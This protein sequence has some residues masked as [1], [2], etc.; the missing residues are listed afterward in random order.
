MNALVKP[1]GLL[2]LAA[3]F[4]LAWLIFSQLGSTS[5]SPQCYGATAAAAEADPPSL[6]PGYEPPADWDRVPER[7]APDAS[8]PLPPPAYV[9]ADDFP[10]E[11]GPPT[12][13]QPVIVDEWSEPTRP[14]R[15]P[16][17]PPRPSSSPARPGNF[18]GLTFPAYPSA[19]TNAPSQDTDEPPAIP[20][21]DFPEQGP[22]PIR[23]PKVPTQPDRE[24]STATIVAPTWSQPRSARVT[25][26]VHYINTTQIEL[27]YEVT[28]VGP[29]GVG[30]VDLWLTLDQGQTWRRFAEDMDL[31]S[32][33]NVDLPAEGIYGLTLIVRNRAGL[34]KEAPMRGDAPEMLVEVDLTA[35]LVLLK[36]PQPIKDRRDQ[37]TLSWE[38]SDRY[39]TESPVTLSWSDKADGPWNEIVANLANTSRYLWTMPARMPHRIYLKLEARDRAGNIGVAQSAEPVLIDL[40]EPESKLTGVAPRS[41]KPFEGLMRRE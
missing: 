23:T 33:I 31:R 3:G 1:V 34:G 25:P 32:P 5:Q 7:S 4:G 18:D 28:Q 30:A 20:Y 39:L 17:L 41:R 12:P 8:G 38:A 37:L 16:Y 29:A 11:P 21:P 35:P 24:G 13:D 36:A 2:G 22:R 19:P 40:L 6:P 27:S 9:P 14:S 26:E 15:I 10:P